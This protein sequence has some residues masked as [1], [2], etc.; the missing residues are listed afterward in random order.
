MVFMVACIGLGC[1]LA[2]ICVEFVV[3]CIGWRIAC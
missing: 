3:D 1:L 2:A